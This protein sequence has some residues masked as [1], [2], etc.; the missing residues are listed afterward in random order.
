VLFLAER[1]ATPGA[2]RGPAGGQRAGEA[3]ALIKQAR[4]P[5]HVTVRALRLSQPDYRMLFRPNM[6]GNNIRSSGCCR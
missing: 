4:Q 1:P 5:R 3:E 2:E 6:G